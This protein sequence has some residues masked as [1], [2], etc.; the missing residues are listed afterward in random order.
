MVEEEEGTWREEVDVEG[1]GLTFETNG[2]GAAEEEEEEDEAVGALV[3]NAK[4]EGGMVVAA[5]VT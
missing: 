5:L 1:D 3:D 4:E 2:D